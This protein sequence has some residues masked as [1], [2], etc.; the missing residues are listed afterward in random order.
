M[1]HGYF[2]IRTLRIFR[3]PRHETKKEFPA[4]HGFIPCSGV[5]NVGGS[6]RRD[7]NAEAHFLL[8]NF[9]SN[10]PKVIPPTGLASYASAR[11][12]SSLSDSGEI[13]VS[14]THLRAHE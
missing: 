3:R 14:Y 11:R 10:C 2:G 13:S 12:S 8:I 1:E 5:K 4:R 6:L 7:D 9:F